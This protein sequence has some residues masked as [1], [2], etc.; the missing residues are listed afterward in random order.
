MT[1]DIGASV[2][3]WVD[4]VRRARLG[5]ITKTVAFAIAQYADAD[6]T[7]VFPGVPRLSVECEL[8]PNTVKVALAAL[9]QAELIEVVRKGTSRGNTDEYRLIL[10]PNVMD[11]IE[12][13]S[14]N[15]LRALIDKLSAKLRGHYKRTP[16]DLRPTGRAAD[17]PDGENLRYVGRAAVAAHSP[18]D[19]PDLQHAGRTADDDSPDGPAARFTGRRNEPAARPTKTCSTSHVPPPFKDLYTTTTNHTTADVEVTV[20]VP[21]VSSPDQEPDSDSEVKPDQ[22]RHAAPDESEHEPTN[23][24]PIRRTA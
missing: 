16:P 8:A 24:I 3:E 4:V 7:R 6:G 23:V 21:R 15:E 18:V 14:P 10:G 17:K 13:L 12:V 20:T 9:R 11:L 22:R 1:D 5:K 19:N 2:R